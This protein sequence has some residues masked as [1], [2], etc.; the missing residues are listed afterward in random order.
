MDEYQLEIRSLRQILERLRAGEADPAVI[1]EYDAELRNLVALY[2]AA[3]ETLT[4]GER[5]PRLPVVLSDLGFGDWTI[6]NVYSFVYEAAMEID[7]A[8][9]RDLAAQINE[10][11]YAASLLAASEVP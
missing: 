5:D 6:E 4:A 2:D 9:G 8:N 11:D 1:D 10:T 7:V 3:R